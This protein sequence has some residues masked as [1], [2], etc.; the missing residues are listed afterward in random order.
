MWTS[1][2]LLM[3]FDPGD[4]PTNPAGTVEVQC[5]DDLAGQPDL[6]ARKCRAARAAQGA[7]GGGNVVII[8]PAAA[9]AAAGI[10]LAGAKQDAPASR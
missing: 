3:T 6:I 4:K 9:A 7:R 5:P 8:L 2:L 10:A 1:F